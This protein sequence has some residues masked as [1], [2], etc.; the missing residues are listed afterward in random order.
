MGTV[1]ILEETTKNPITKIGMMAGVCYGSD[2]R[3]QEANYKRGLSCIETNHGRTLEFPTVE[4]ILDGYSAKVIR[5]WY[6]HI[7]CLPTRLQ[8]S[9]RYIDYS[10]FKYITP[11]SI[12]NNAEALSIYEETMKHISNSVIKLIEFGV[13]NEDATMQLPLCMCTMIV[14]KRNM[15][16]LIDMSRNRDC[17]RAYWE[18]RELMNDI[19]KALKAYSDEWETLVNLTM[20]PKCEYLGRC[21][22]K[23]SC[24]RVPK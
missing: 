4:M 19:E 23:H 11:P 10:N 15:R 18:F 24:G 2:I 5:E 9:T 1:T 22:E 3:N 14:D 8:A 6:T 20:M 17:T 13:P 21:P 16:N 12:Q 7:G